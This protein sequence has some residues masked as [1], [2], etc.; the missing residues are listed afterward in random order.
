[1]T[2][3]DLEDFVKSY[4]PENRFKRNETERFQVFGYDE[5]IQRNKANLDLFWLKD[6]SLVDSENLPDPDVLAEEISDSLEFALEQFQSI[7]EN[8]NR[9]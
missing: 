8:L 3:E 6:A 7:K 2:Y 5:L 4:N 1:L 9:K